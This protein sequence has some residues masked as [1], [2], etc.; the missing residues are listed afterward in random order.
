MGTLV[1]EAIADASDCELVGL[2][3]PPAAGH[4]VAGLS[5]VDDPGELAAADVMVE[6][7][8]P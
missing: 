3:D 8:N 7:T 2:F 4:E 6:F 5:I 1:A